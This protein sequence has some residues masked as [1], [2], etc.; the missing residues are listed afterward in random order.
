MIQ[1]T[2]NCIQARIVEY[3]SV[4]SAARRKDEMESGGFISLL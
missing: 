4:K 1:L 2:N 3:G